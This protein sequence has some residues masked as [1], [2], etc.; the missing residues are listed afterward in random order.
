MKKEIVAKLN[1]NFEEAAYQE[2]GVEYW[3]A[4]DLQMEQLFSSNRKS[5]NRMR[6]LWPM[7]I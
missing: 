7:Y 6:E 5:K 4:R 1:M 2:D 3:F